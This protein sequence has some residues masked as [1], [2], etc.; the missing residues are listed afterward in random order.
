MA[1]YR[2]AGTQAEE[3]KKKH[4]ISY[5][6]KE[7]VECPVCSGKFK[8]EVMHQGGGRA[9]A[10]DLSD[11]LHRNYEPSKKYGR[12]YPLIYDIGCCPKCHTAFF[13][14]DFKEIRD[15]ETFGR[16][17]LEKKKRLESVEA[18]FPHFNVERERTLY[19]G[20]A[21]YYLALLCYDKTSLSY[22][23]TFK[24]AQIS[25][26]LAW[27]CNEIEAACPGH[28]YNYIAQV[29]YRKALFFYQQTLENEVDRVESIEGIS[30]F[31]PDTDKNYGYDGVVYLSGLLEL[32]YGQRE[33]ME[34]RLKK[35]DHYKKGI[36]RIFGLGKSSK[37]KPGPLLDV[38][39]ELYDKMTVEL[40]SNNVFDDD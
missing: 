4:A 19:D 26:R 39:K 35:I 40:S 36:A 13:W 33:D 2:K 34:L 14:K 29:F 28:N 24:R 21:M 11:E 1:Y 9:I 5:W 3:S 17:M 32:K 20:A 18:I 27:L 8:Q 12:V 15:N 38:T 23:P 30:N 31:G 25:L 22:A 7:M 37:E 10:G 6:A 16:L